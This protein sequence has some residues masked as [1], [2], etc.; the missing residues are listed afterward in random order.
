MLNAG[1]AMSTVKLR[2]RGLLK[3]LRDLLRHA[4]LTQSMVALEREAGLSPDEYPAELLFFRDLILEGEWSEVVNLVQLLAHS[5]SYSDVMYAV[6]RQRFLEL[7]HI[8]GQPSPPPPGT[9]PAPRRGE[10]QDHLQ[11][12]ERL[13]P[14]RTEFATLSCLITL[15]NLT[16]HPVFSDWEVKASRHQLFQCIGRKMAEAIYHGAVDRVFPLSASGDLAGDRLVQLVAK[17]LLYEQCEA[18]VAEHLVGTP[19]QSQGIVNLQKCISA[20]LTRSRQHELI[21]QTVSVEVEDGVQPVAEGDGL[22]SQRLSAAKSPA[23]MAGYSDHMPAP[24]NGRWHVGGDCALSGGR[25]TG[26]RVLLTPE[27]S[28]TH[29]VAIPQ[30]P[31][32]VA[33]FGQTQTPVVEHT[34]PEKARGQTDE[35]AGLDEKCPGGTSGSPSTCPAGVVPS[36]PTA[37]RGGP[38]VAGKDV[39]PLQTTLFSPLA[40]EERN[41]SDHSSPVSST[42]PPQRDVKQSSVLQKQLIGDHPDA[43]SGL[44]T[45]SDLVPRHASFRSLPATTSGPWVERTAS[46]RSANLHEPDPTAPSAPHQANSPPAALVSSHTQRSEGGGGRLLESLQ[47]SSSLHHPPSQAT[48]PVS[49]EGVNQAAGSSAVRVPEGVP[50]L[51]RIATPDLAL[52]PETAIDSSTPKPTNSRLMG[53][54]GGVPPTSPVPYVSGTHG[55]SDT[56]HRRGVRLRKTLSEAME[57]VGDG[58][59][60]QELASQQAEPVSDTQH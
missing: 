24:A 40:E 44:T 56:P 16:D 4:Q 6:E 30:R 35:V 18:T 52:P 51:S 32:T 19:G 37:A 39:A 43:Q 28:H 47:P 10:I 58:G 46:Q 29:I 34:A 53:R 9:C 48:H 2:R 25:P 22:V 3:L 54:A 21:S 60:S 42:K 36:T 45:P 50:H 57:E 59:R 38:A 11:R 41:Q 8:R 13:C 5:D 55:L 23:S 33:C 17:G 49:V 20:V 7:L 15:P 1:N 14:S 12:L 31:K 26:P 27:P